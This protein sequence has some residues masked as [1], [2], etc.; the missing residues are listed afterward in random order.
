MSLSEYL[1]KPQ[2]LDDIVTEVPLPTYIHQQVIPAYDDQPEHYHLD[3]NYVV[4]LPEMK[5]TLE[6]GAAHDIRWFTKEQLDTIDV[7]ADLQP[8]LMQLLK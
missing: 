8:I 4:Y 6:A 5:V 1:P 3:Q 7:I 2:R